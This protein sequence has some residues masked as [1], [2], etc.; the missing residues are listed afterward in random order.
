MP[1]GNEVDSDNS[2][3]SGWMKGVLCLRVE[4]SCRRL[5]FVDTTWYI[6]VIVNLKY[7]LSLISI[8]RLLHS[9]GGV[10]TEVCGLWAGKRLAL[11]TF[12]A[13]SF[14]VRCAF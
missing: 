1:Q 2:S 7:L 5:D 9:V 3:K 8:C 10:H 6:T 11:G 13:C 4:A 12:D 14:D